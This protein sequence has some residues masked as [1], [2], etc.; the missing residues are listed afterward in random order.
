VIDEEVEAILRE[1]EQ[2]T[3]ATLT[4]FRPALDSIARALLESETLDGDDITRLADE[5]MGYKAGGARTP[6]Q[7]DG[8]TP[9]PVGA[10]PSSTANGDSNSTP[11][12][13]AG[14]PPAPPPPPL[15]PPF[16][17]ASGD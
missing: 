14:A 8:V 17:P 16:T 12:G 1:Q 13:P 10:A 6:V 2:R 4:K 3:Q 7:A 11:Q 9:V 15:R 5:A